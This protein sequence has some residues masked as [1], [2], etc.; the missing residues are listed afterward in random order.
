MCPFLDE[1]DFEEELIDVP[2]QEDEPRQSYFQRNDKKFFVIGGVASII[3]F[4]TV[5]YFLYS[6]SKPLNLEDLPI[7]QADTTPIK[8][9]P[10]TNKQ[11]DHQDK[12]VYDNISD[13]VPQ[14]KE[15][16]R[17]M[18]QPEEILTISDVDGGNGE[19][20]S[21]EEKK[22]I[23]NAFDELAPGSEKEYKI[24]YVTTDNKKNTKDIEVNPDYKVD[25]ELLPPIKRTVKKKRHKR[26]ADFVD[27][28][29]KKPKKSQPQ[30][31]QQKKKE[32][33]LSNK[34]RQQQSWTK[35]RY[36]ENDDVYTS[37][38]L[39]PDNKKSVRNREVR[40][41]NAG[42]MVQIASVPTKLGAESEYSRIVNRNRT[43][44]KYGKRIYRA[45]LGHN[46]GNTYRVQIGPFRSNA[47]AQR[48]ISTLRSNGCNAYIVR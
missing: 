43:V 33:K 34:P 46:R 24:N 5:A 26:L 3:A 48:V 13:V 31:R 39:A 40:S 42:I 29:L 2:Q 45:D 9:R 1:E 6:N 28:N 35:L 11:V 22:K 12:V 4:S 19:V 41:N 38:F 17:V 10:K 23:I 32:K 15:E 44:R 18:P 37:S 27:E 36:D 21:E 7:V 30:L 25:D 14:R 8:V 47:E 20:L 16:E